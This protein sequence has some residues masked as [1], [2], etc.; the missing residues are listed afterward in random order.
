MPEDAV[1]GGVL[2]RTV[3]S[4]RFDELMEA[5]YPQEE[6]Y[7]L[8]KRFDVDLHEAIDLLRAGCPVETA[9]RILT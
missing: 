2:P 6:A 9:I 3:R 8:A 5:G 7:L 4:W 1:R